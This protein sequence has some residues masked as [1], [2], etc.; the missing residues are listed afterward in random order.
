MKR[1]LIPLMVFAVLVGFLAIGLMR[2]PHEV[3]SPLV[4]KP[5]PVFSLPQLATG[6]ADFSPQQMRGKVWLLNVWSTWCVSCR[7][8]HA[9]LV[10]LAGQTQIPIIGLNYKEVRGDGQLDARKLSPAEEM[11]LVRKRANAWMAEHGNPYQISALDL[12]GRVGIDYGVY[13]VPE[14]YLID[15][16]GVIRFKQIGPLTPEAMQ[17]RILPLIQKL[18]PRS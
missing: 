16:E 3:P 17:T 8:E 15:R 18:E 12:D 13:G 6:A 7:A 2:D 14:T 5:A 11:Q 1:F 9:Y 10:E 4:G